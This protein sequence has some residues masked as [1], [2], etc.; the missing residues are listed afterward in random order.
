MKKIFFTGLFLVCVVAAFAQ[1][2]TVA[3]FPFEAKGGT[4]KVDAETITETFSIKLQATGAIK[5]V[6]RSVIDRVIDQEHL[7]QL[8]DLSSGSKTAEL[9]KGLNADWVV[10]G[11]V[12]RLGASFVVNATLFDLNTQE[13]MGGAPMQMNRI[14]DAFTAMDAPINAMIQRLTSRSGGQAIKSG[15]TDPVYKIG[16]FGPVGGIVFYDKGRFSNGWR[17]LEAAPAETEFNVPWGAYQKDV[18]D[19]SGGLGTGKTNTEAIV[20]YLRQ[21]GETGKAAQLCDNLV[22]DDFDDWFL[23]SKEELNLMY[24]NLKAKGLGDF[25]NKWYWSSSQYSDYGAWIQRFGDGGQDGY[26]GKNE[27]NCVRAVRA[28]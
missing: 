4:S 15:A 22:F 13:V 23:P 27:V 24:V 3:V 11:T 28:F 2:V 1:Q 18:S 9:K 6:L 5:L 16:D 8:G 7:Y 17:Y 26:D 20:R 25:Q 14:D 12:S 10:Y 19:T 21:I